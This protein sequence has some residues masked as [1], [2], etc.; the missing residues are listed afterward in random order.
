MQI[1]YISQCAANAS[2]RPKLEDLLIGDKKKTDAVFEDDAAFASALVGFG[3][4]LP[5]V[6]NEE[7]PSAE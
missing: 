7:E 2:K 4:T 1:A 6:K 3:A 5:I